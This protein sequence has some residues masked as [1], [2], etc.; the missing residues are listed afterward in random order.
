MVKGPKATK[1]EEMLRGK[2]GNKKKIKLS[3]SQYEKQIGKLPKLKSINQ[4]SALKNVADAYGYK[5]E[6]RPLEIYFIKTE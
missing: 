3:I 4:S 2:L 5:I 1:I 6:I